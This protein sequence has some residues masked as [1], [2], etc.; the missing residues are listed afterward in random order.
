MKTSSCKAKGRRLQKAVVA[1]ILAEF[2]DLTDRDVQSTSMGATGEDIKLS[3]AAYKC[4]PLSFECKNQE[5]NKSLIKSWEQA[6][7]HTKNSAA[8]VLSANSLPILAVVK[9]DLLIALYSKIYAGRNG[10]S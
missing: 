9:L 6:Q 2:L 8:L 3:E 10:T 1:S 5:I 4:I 7:S